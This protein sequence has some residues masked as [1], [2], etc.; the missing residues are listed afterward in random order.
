MNV[1]VDGTGSEDLAVPRHDLGGRTDDQRR[2]H[3]IHRV[4]IARLAD[5]ANTSVAHAD[6][7]LDHTP[8]I[9]DDCTGDDQIGCPLRAGCARLAHRFANDLAAAEDDL[10]A[11]DTQITLDLDEQIGVGQADAI[12]GGGAEQSA[13]RGARDLSHRSARQPRRGT[14]RRCA[15]HRT[16]RE[17]LRC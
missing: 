16:Q 2:M 10:V 4:G 5:A 12:V 6:V 14:L 17:S 15:R 8:V 11:T 13:V 1:A 3:A 7:G 9:E